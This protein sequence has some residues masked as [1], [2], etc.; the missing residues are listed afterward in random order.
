M[1]PQTFLDKVKDVSMLDLASQY[2]QLKK[3]GA[4]VW[5]GTCPKPNHNDG[6]PSFVVWE[7]SNSWCCMGCHNGKKGQ[8]N[9]G[10]DTIAF[11]QWIEDLKWRDAVLKVAEF[12]DIPKP[13]EENDK[14]LDRNFKLTQKFVKDLNEETY[15]YLLSRGLSD[16]DMRKW[17][18]GYD[19]FEDRIVFPLMDKYKNILGFNKRVLTPTTDE[20][21]K[22][23]NSS[24]SKIFNKSKYFYGIQNID[25]NYPYIR[26]TEGSM[27]VILSDKFGL[28]NVVASLGTAFTEDHAKEIKK[29]GLIPVLIFDGDE[30]G[31]NAILK[32]VEL[33]NA[34]GIYS[35][36]MRLPEGID[37]AELSLQCGASIEEYVTS[38]SVTYGY[39]KIRSII[40][41]YNK[42]LY[43]LKLKMYP[44]VNE[45]LSVVPYNE[46][47]A[48]K[49]FL[50]DEINMKV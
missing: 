42:E 19:K 6:T 10:S 20:G 30:A 48:L 31:A 49:S 27:D 17:L 45:L 18:I 16:E 32:A 25:K 9:Y 47:D 33:L 5:Q 15:E 26:I 4:N 40:D 35:K 2:T 23:I 24:N 44:K 29:M 21:K 34:E 14:E 7:K 39:D 11:M 50:F 12:A 46:K 43:E 28:K 3:A 13:S 37:L 8:K 1:F 36:I 22:Y 41:E 38:K